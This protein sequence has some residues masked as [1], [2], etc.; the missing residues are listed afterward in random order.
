LAVAGA[1]L[2][3]DQSWWFLLFWA[4]DFF[5]RTYGL[6]LSKLGAPLAIVYGLA[7]AGSMT[8]GW[9]SSRALRRGASLDR[10][11]KGTML[12]A[13]LLVTPIPLVVLADSPY[14][15][16]AMLGLALFGHQAFSTNLF[17][18][19][20]DVFPSRI[21]GSAIGIAATVGTLGGMG[22]LELAGVSLDRGW[23]YL[24]MFAICAVAYVLALGWIQL[25]LPRLKAAEAPLTA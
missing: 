17:A 9:V 22:I 13:A 10:A 16:A 19:T 12:A 25:L 21:V 23:G 6:T 18:L 1:K 2:L 4:P 8:G 24:P 7:A 15:A 20:T 5:S 3:S 14:L 11:R